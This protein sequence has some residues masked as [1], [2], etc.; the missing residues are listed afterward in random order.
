MQ[1]KSTVLRYLSL[2]LPFNIYTVHQKLIYEPPRNSNDFSSSKMSLNFCHLPVTMAYLPSCA[3]KNTHIKKTHSLED[4]TCQ[5]VSFFLHL[6]SL[7]RSRDKGRKQSKIVFFAKHSFVP[8]KTHQSQLYV[9]VI[10]TQKS[11]ILIW[12]NNHCFLNRFILQTL[13]IFKMILCNSL[14]METKI[15]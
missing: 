2:P 14:I 10:C 11:V 15:A 12:S 5:K 4:K 6:F 7:S 3:A 8:G 1:K 13:F 9:V